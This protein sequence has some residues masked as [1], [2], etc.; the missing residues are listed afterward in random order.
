MGAARVH[1]ADVGE[2]DMD[3]RTAT[4]MSIRTRCQT[5]YSSTNHRC[6]PRGSVAVAAGKMH[7]AALSKASLCPETVRGKPYSFRR[8]V[9]CRLGRLAR[10]FRIHDKGGAFIGGIEHKRIRRIWGRLRI[11]YVEAIAHIHLRFEMRRLEVIVADLEHFPEGQV[12][13]IS[14]PRQIRRRQAERIGL[15]LE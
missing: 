2:A 8:P 10:D 12:R 7:T 6:R 15:D 5:I 13:T 9:R 1:H 11:E 3:V 4:P 14:M